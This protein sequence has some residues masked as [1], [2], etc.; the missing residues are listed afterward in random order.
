MQQLWT[1]KERKKAADP[2]KA[3]GR[4]G[5]PVRHPCLH[6]HPFHEVWEGFGM[7]LSSPALA[8]PSHQVLNHRFKL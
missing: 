7:H 3:S 1:Q 4:Q 8:L 6:C 5:S 2:W